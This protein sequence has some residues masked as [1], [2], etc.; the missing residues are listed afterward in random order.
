MAP[1]RSSLFSAAGTLRDLYSSLDWTTTP[2]G[3]VQEWSP[4]L[5]AAVDTMLRTRF[6]ITLLWGPEFVLV[7][8]EAYVELIGDKH[9][10]ALGR[11]AGEI[12]EEAW[13]LIAPMMEEVRAGGSSTW[14]EDQYLPLTRRGFLEECYF[15]FSYSAVLGRD[16]QIEGVLDISAETTGKVIG[17]RRQ[18]L[19]GDL[20]QSLSDATDLAE[21]VL[22]AGKVLA[23]DPADLAVAN[24]WVPDAAPATTRPGEWLPP[25]PPDDTEWEGGESLVRDP[26]SHGTATIWL[27]LPDLP[28]G[29]ATESRTP[30]LVVRCSELLPLDEPYRVFLRLVADTL[31]Q[32]MRRL[33]ARHAEDV[34]REQERGFSTALQRSLLTAPVQHPTISVA[35][36]YEPATE[37]AHVGGDWHDSF[38]LGDGTLTLVIG[39]VAG[40]DR[41]AAAS[42]AQLRNILRGI[43]SILEESPAAVLRAVDRAVDGL[44]VDALATAILARVEEADDSLVLRWSNA[45]H[46]PPVLLRANGSA[47][48]LA[49]DPDLLLGVDAAASRVDNLHVLEPGCIVVLYTDGLVERRGRD[50]SSGLSWLTSILE[51]SGERDPERL[52]DLLLATMPAGAEDDVAIL[53][54]RTPSA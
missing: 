37:I 15:T 45:G 22:R 26:L 19:L 34:V 3:P 11:P 21:L 53:V 8:N 35:S 20:A 25:Q 49:D 54:V 48:L 28:A 36:R 47:E 29:T 24:L 46:P 33:A 4:T 40:H 6:P 14:L 23:T 51:A 41:D 17:A 38:I 31:A 39:D 2:L 16:G 30:M 27:R 32:A 42:M 12:F 9:P 1:A 50:L 5:V 10:A 52:A 7:Y 44:H 13:D 18:Q 43:A